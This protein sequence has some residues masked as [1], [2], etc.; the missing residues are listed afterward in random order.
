MVDTCH[1]AGVKVVADAVINHMCG[2]HP[3]PAPAGTS[4]SKYELPGRLLRTRTS[5][6]A[7]RT[8][9]NYNDRDNVQNCEL[10]GLADLDTGSDYV[11]RHDRRVPRRPARRLGVDGFRIDAAKHIA[12]A[13]LADIKS[14]MSNPGV[15]WKQ[16]V[17][18]GGGEAVQPDEYTGHRRRRTSSAT[19]ATSSASS[20][21]RTSPT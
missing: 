1:G 15:Y 13:D 18:Y 5:T 8:I 19:R 7:A 20:R 10:V 11:R 12:A 17:I 14:R 9:T 2:R 6:A 21:A 3:V 4:Y 16:E